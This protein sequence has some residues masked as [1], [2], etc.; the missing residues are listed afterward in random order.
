M[1]K[2]KEVRRVVLDTNILVSALIFRGELA[3]L[4]DAWK[5]GDII[6]IISKETFEEF[7]AVLS[8]PKFRL[9][10]SEI[11][12]IVEDEVLPYFEVIE[13]TAEVIGVCKDPDDDMFIACAISAKAD[14]IVSG[15]KAL[16]D[17]GRYKSVRIITAT[18]FLKKL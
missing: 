8:Y 17:V 3:R 7:H 14:F 4:V 12:A 2:K 9:T 10:D 18:E 11:K 13:K 1:G 15:D 6:P 5:S 16:C